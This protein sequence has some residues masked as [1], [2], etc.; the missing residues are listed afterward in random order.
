[1]LCY[2]DLDFLSVRFQHRKSSSHYWLS[3]RSRVGLWPLKSIP[4]IYLVDLQSQRTSI[5]ILVFGISEKCNMQKD[6]EFVLTRRS[7]YCIV[8]LTYIYRDVDSIARN[9][10]CQHKNRRIFSMKDC[11]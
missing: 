3:S 8:N 4:G 5:L 2:L 1:M 10:A 11:Q 6:Y 9:L 7:V